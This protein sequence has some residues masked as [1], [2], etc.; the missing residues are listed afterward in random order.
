MLDEICL[1][2]RM[3]SSI[4]NGIMTFNELHKVTSGIMWHRFESIIV[5]LI[6]IKVI[7]SK[8]SMSL[9]FNDHIMQYYTCH[10]N[11]FKRFKVEKTSK[12]AHNCKSR[13]KY[14]KCTFDILPRRLLCGSKMLSFTVLWCWNCFDKCCPWWIYTICKIVPHRIVI[15]IYRVI[16]Q[17]STP[18][19]KLRKYRRPL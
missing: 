17:E 4:S 19:S 18:F 5:D 9:I 14:S 16:N 6:I 7:C 11:V 2:L 12:P 8:V 13:L 3:N 1:K 10:H 15:T